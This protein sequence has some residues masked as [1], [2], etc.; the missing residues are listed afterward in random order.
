MSNH[1]SQRNIYL[2]SSCKVIICVNGTFLHNVSLYMREQIREQRHE[3]F[4]WLHV[5]TKPQLLGHSVLN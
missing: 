5:V 3:S 1:R 4:Q 2:F